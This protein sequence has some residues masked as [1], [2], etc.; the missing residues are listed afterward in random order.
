MVSLEF[1]ENKPVTVEKDVA[2]KFSDRDIVRCFLKFQCLI[3]DAFAAI[4]F[5]DVGV[6]RTRASS[7][8]DGLAETSKMKSVNSSLT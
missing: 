2:R 6:K 4:R 1:S 8:S 7:N 3:V 5:D